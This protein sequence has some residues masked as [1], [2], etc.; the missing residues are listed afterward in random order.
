MAGLAS[1]VGSYLGL[2]VTYDE[3]MTD[4]D[5]LRDP[6]NYSISQVAASGVNSAEVLSVTPEDVVNPTYVD[7]DCSDVTDGSVYKV[8]I[9]SGVMR[10]A[11]NVL[12]IAGLDVN[13]VGVSELPSVQSI[14]AISLYEMEVVFTKEIS[15]TSD[16]EDESRYSFDNGLQVRSVTIIAPGIV[17]LST[18]RQ[19]PSELY[20]LTVS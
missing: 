7:L 15:P 11:M 4:N 9:V 5:A 1:A 8:T 14:K 17:R 16:V 10:T 6:S 12:V 13:F 20:T 18:S 19:T 2:R 3:A